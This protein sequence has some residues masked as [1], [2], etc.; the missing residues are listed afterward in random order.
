MRVK[1]LTYLHKELIHMKIRSIL[2]ITALAL[3]FAVPARAQLV[4][5]GA[6]LGMGFPGFVDEYIASQRITLATS[7]T[8]SLNFSDHLRFQV[9]LGFQRK[10]N[11]YSYQVWDNDGNVIEDSTYLVK[12]N[13]DYITIPA[14]MKLQFGGSNSFYIQG[15]A[16]YG[17]L[18]SAKFTGKMN[19]E[20]VK[21]V[22]IY[23]GLSPHDF[24]II[25]GGG[26]MS[27]VREGLAVVLDIK[28]QI[29]LK[30]LN[31]NPVITGQSQALK[32][33]GLAM[34][35]GFIIDVE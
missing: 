27:P 10:G 22:N 26:I 3:L 4:S 16:Y 24:G 1:T 17:Y 15:G 7:L 5:F 33:K 19:E 29:G 12:T 6:K 8:G 11:K 20:M 30:D 28:Y 34:S 32:N 35:M 13:L 2:L 18:L 31:L 9:D 21:K 14:Y 23:D 25:A